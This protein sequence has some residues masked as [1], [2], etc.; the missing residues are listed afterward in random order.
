[1]SKVIIKNNLAKYYKQRGCT[2][3]WL[4]NQYIELADKDIGYA[5]INKLLDNETEITACEAVYFA[6]A[7]EISDWT[8]LLVLDNL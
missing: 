2:L 8:E 1:M 3:T 5:R 7:L 6:K 4:T